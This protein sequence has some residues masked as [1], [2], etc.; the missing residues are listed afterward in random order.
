MQG[1]GLYLPLFI[2]YIDG[3]VTDNKK[4]LINLG[5]RKLGKIRL[6]DC[7]FEDEK[8]IVAGYKR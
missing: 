8:T 3:I 2:L 6:T 7:V 1:W 4:I 5:Y